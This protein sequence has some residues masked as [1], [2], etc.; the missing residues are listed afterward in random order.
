MFNHRA[1][2][3][4]RITSRIKN[5]DYLRAWVMP[6]LLML[7]LPSLLFN[8]SIAGTHPPEFLWH[9]PWTDSRLLSNFYLL[10]TPACEAY[11][12]QTYPPSGL[13]NVIAVIDNPFVVNSANSAS[14]FYT[15]WNGQVTVFTKV[16]YEGV[17]FSSNN[18]FT[19][20]SF[21]QMCYDNCF[22]PAVFSNDTKTCVNPERYTL[23]LKTLN[24]IEPSDSSFDNS[25]TVI[26]TVVNA[27][28]LQPKE[29]VRVSIKVD[30]DAG[31][32]GH[33][34]DTGRHVSP[35]TGTLDTTN[36]ITGSNGTFTFTFTAPEVSGTHT[37]T[38]T[39]VSPTC[40]NS[41]ATTKINVMV[42]GLATI[43]ASVF[44]RPISPNGDINHPD[45][46]N[47][48]PEASAKLAA[49][50]KAYYEATYLFKDGWI[51]NVMLN[52]ASLNWGGILDCFLTCINSVP[53]SVP[54]GPAHE[55]HRRGSVVDI[56]ARL[57]AVNNPQVDTLLYEK[58]FKK[59]ALDAGA[60]PH[61]ESSGNGR[62][63]HL[64]LFGV[65]E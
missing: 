25:A 7:L 22:A 47:L 26:A 60:E 32:G 48:K 18:V 62:H 15:Q 5:M 8:K 13:P 51:P 30:V 20:L 63:Y 56:R 45:N 27:Q 39:C 2:T 1:V 44:Y 64:R 16:S 52:D 28:T 53:P 43:P 33:V 36:G 49:I 17:C 42:D 35:Y 41:T 21:N 11:S 61:L 23:S 50:A 9:Q 46:H 57:P 40:T 10:P 19:G 54:W 24:E 6:I 4:P 65:K 59:A 29:G 34:H 38:A 12:Q 31:S 37:F 55:E 14:C 58:E 3:K